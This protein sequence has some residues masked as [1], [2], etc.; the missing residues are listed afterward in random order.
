MRTFYR[1]D[2]DLH[3]PT[4]LTRGPW[5]DV[6]QHGGPPC[7][8]LG[9]AIEAALATPSHRVVR[10]TV[11]LRRPIA[12]APLRAVAR[13]IELGR[14][15]QRLAATLEQG[16]H[17]VARA[18]ALAVHV[19]AI[20]IPALAADPPPPLPDGLAPFALPLF[21]DRVGYDKAMDLRIARGTWGAGPV[22]A[23]LRMRVPLVDD[24]PPSPLVRVL[25]AADSGNG[26]SPVLDP[27]RFTFLNADLTVNVF[28]PPSGEWIGL[29]AVSS[30]MPSGLGLADARLF[31]EQG[32]IGRATQSLVVRSVERP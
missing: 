1:T 12:L 20:E 25:C 5:T 15:V 30:A 11:E 21:P 14:T 8:L 16:D 32:P 29:D 31:D 28:R 4:E 3:V 17:E 7:A 24:E 6:H 2:G 10:V 9:R 18:T 22:A 23:W 27:A 26:V 19:A 13:S